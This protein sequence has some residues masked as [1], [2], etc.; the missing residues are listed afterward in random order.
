[1]KTFT[2]Y[3]HNMEEYQPKVHTLLHQEDTNQLPFHDHIFSTFLVLNMQ[4][5]HK[6]TLLQLNDQEHL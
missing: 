2:Y 3:L 4:Q 5:I 6:T 1:M